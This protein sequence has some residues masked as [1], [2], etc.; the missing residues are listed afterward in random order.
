MGVRLDIF[1]IGCWRANWR[2]PKSIDLLP[3]CPSCNLHASSGDQHALNLKFIEST[4]ILLG[5]FA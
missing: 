5:I 2:A 4:K 1:E 3:S